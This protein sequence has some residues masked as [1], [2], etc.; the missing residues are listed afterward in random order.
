MTADQQII[1]GVRSSC[2][3]TDVN[4]DFTSF[5]NTFLHRHLSDGVEILPHDVVIAIAVREA[6]MI[7]PPQV[8]L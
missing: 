1:M 6:A 2:S 8:D 5:K 4:C 7:C 3:F